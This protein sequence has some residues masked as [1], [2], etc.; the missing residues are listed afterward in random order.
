[1]IQA[2]FIGTGST[3]DTGFGSERSGFKLTT[4]YQISD[5]VGLDLNMHIQTRLS[6]NLSTEVK[7]FRV[8]LMRL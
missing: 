4:Y 7:K 8:R 3:E 1:M 2:L 6:L 5:T